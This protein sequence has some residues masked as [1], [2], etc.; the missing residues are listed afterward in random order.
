MADSYAYRVSPAL[1]EVNRS[2]ATFLQL[3]GGT[4]GIVASI[5]ISAATLVGVKLLGANLG[6]AKKEAEEL[7][8]AFRAVA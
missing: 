2:A 3:S 8:L 7:S 6:E 1:A 5:V 4:V